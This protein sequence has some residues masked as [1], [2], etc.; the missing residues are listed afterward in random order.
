[1]TIKNKSSNIMGSGSS[2]ISSVVNGSDYS[3]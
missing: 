3:S 2:N 1:M